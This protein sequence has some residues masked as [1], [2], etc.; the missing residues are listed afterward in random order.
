MYE[1]FDN[2]LDLDTWHTM[3]ANDCERFYQALAQVVHDSNFNADK[4]GE[5]MRN[6]TGVKRDDES[7][8]QLSAAIDRRVQNAWAVRDYLNIAGR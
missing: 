3:H 2:F 4:L 7:Y 1:A 5:Y 8:H 6:K